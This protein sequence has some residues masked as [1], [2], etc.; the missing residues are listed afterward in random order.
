M[1]SESLK[2]RGSGNEHGH[3][4]EETITPV[5]ENGD[6]VAQFSPRSQ[7]LSDDSIAFDR[8]LPDLVPYSSSQTSEEYPYLLNHSSARSLDEYDGLFDDFPL[9]LNTIC[10][11]FT[12]SDGL[13]WLIV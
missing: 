6:S 5:E 2:R 8:L 4:V 10:R 9:I 3:T 12:N 7:C 13:H 11:C 1:I